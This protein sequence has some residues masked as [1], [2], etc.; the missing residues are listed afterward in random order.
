MK[1]NPDKKQV[2]LGLVLITIILGLIIWGLS[3]VWSWFSSLDPKLAAG[4]VTASST[5]VVATLTLVVGRYFERVKEA[6]SHLREKKIEMY[7]EFLQELF[8]LFNSV[9]DEKEGTPEEVESDDLVEFLQEWQRKL[10]V[11]GGAP[12]LK[13]F[14]DWN[15]FMQGNEPCAKT[16]YLM[17]E[18]FRAMRK[19]IGLSN[20][21]LEKGFFAHVILRN[22][23]LFLEMAKKNPNVTLAELSEF[24][25]KQGL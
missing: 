1:N 20:K 13:S 25:K 11:W 15:N 2:I 21:Q 6:E 7:D 3:T 17:D 12:V 22:S 5:V 8:K 23:E 4:L 19:D 18:F 14:M 10:I 9:K 16:I 24:E